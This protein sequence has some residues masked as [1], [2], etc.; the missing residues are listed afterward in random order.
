MSTGVMRTPWG[1]FTKEELKKFGFLSLIFAFTI[2]VYW[3]LRPL[4]DG[5]FNSYVGAQSIPFAKWV[6]LFIVLPL[7][8]IYSKLVD[9]FPRQRVFYMLSILYGSLALLFAF[10]FLNPKLGLQNVVTE[11]VDGKVISTGHALKGMGKLIG[12][13][14]YTFVESF[15]SIMVVLFWTFAADT[16]TPESGKRGYPIINFGA[17]VGGIAGPLLVSTKVQK[18]GEAPL[19]IGGAFCIFAIGAL[20]WLFMRITPKEQLSGYHGK[21]E[22]KKSKT[23]ALEGLRLMFTYP[24]LLGIFAVISIYEVIVTIFD[25]YLKYLASREYAGAAYTAY[26]GN[27]GVW[28]N[29]VAAIC[30]FLDV[31]RIGRKLGLRTALLVT[32]VVIGVTVIILKMSPTLSAAFGI[33]VFAKALNYA[34]NQ[35]TKEQLYIPTTKETKY[36]AKAFV[37][38][39]GSRGS[40]ASGSAINMFN[41]LLKPETFVLF[42]TIASLGLVGVWLYT[43]IY[44]G[45]KYK[46]AVDKNTVVC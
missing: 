19:L 25:F 46:E 23:G 2:G 31:N 22:D 44:L 41:K 32:P 6:S 18:L 38:M 39:F 16:T 5:V 21:G 30:I 10:I 28:V 35:P 4:K 29:T 11:L 8:I 12:Y 24:Y 43:A 33:M 26:M 42:T 37:E 27:F 40:K 15:G 9:I 20:I 3:L 14:W 13:S 17:Q 36:K 34:L 1:D 7:G 45:N